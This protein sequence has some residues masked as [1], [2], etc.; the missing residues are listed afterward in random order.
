[1]KSSRL[2]R[3]QANDI[4]TLAKTVSQGRILVCRVVEAREVDWRRYVGALVE[5]NRIV[6]KIETDLN[7]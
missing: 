2:P 5:L 3:G 6:D 7:F 4:L 1:M